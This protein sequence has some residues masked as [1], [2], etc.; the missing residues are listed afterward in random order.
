MSLKGGMSATELF[1]T[2]DD[3]R[4]GKKKAIKKLNEYVQKGS[5]STQ[6][7]NK[8]MTAYRINKDKK[9]M[10]LSRKIKSVLSVVILF[11]SMLCGLVY[12]IEQHG[13]GTAVLY[14]FLWVWAISYALSS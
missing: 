1:D 6:E 11:V 5:I 13:K 10:E 2:I 7:Y 14:I 8:L 3:A 9:D 12:V 4:K